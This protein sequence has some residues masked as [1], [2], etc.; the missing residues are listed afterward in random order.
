MINNWCTHYP[1]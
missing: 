1:V